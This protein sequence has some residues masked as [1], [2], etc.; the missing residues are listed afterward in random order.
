MENQLPPVAVATTA[1]TIPV[2]AVAV[3]TV[4]FQDEDEADKSDD[5]ESL[6][7]A[8]RLNDAMTAVEVEPILLDSPVVDFGPSAGM[9]LQQ[10]ESLALQNNPTIAE[11]V[12]TTQKA[13]GYRTQVSLRANPSIGYQANQL[14]DQGTDQHTFFISQTI[15]TANKLALN[16]SVLSETLR[17]QLLNLE[18]Q[19]FRVATD[20][21]VKFYDAL[22]AQ[23]RVQLIQDFQSVS[24]QG[25]RFAELRKEAEEGSQ[26]DVVQAKVLKN[27]ID[28]Q[29]RQARV[30][31]DAAWRELV[32]FAGAPQMAPT[33]LQ[34]ELPKN[35]TPMDWNN[36]AANIVISNPEYQSAQARV[37]RARATDL[38]S[39][40]PAGSESRR[41]AGQWL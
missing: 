27:E 18:A 19:K 12:A 16:R 30:R 6:R 15:V 21:R 7:E 33:N 41:F 4:A 9:T 14:A 8:M 3:R 23:R 40:S 2:Q 20:I 37:A 36:V 11:L 24:D 22:A 1:A 32:A 13:A 5:L 34:G 39:R 28:L 29:L 35:E 26:L 38:S 17:A 10:F 31:F 25:L